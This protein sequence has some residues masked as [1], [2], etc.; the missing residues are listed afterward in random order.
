MYMYIHIYTLLYSNIQWIKWHFNSCRYDSFLTIFTFIFN[1]YLI[2]KD[3]KLEGSLEFLSNIII[4][5]KYILSEE[6]L[7]IYGNIL[8][9]KYNHSFQQ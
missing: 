2:K 4:A 6:L 9:Q 5:N 3:I 7:M 8:S 1:V